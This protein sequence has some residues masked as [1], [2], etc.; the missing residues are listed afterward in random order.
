MRHSCVTY[1]HF[2]V[3]TQ[4]MY[5]NHIKILS[6]YCTYN[7]SQTSLCFYTGNL[8]LRL[9]SLHHL[10]KTIVHILWT[11]QRRR[12]T[13]KW[14]VKDVRLVICACLS[15]LPVSALFLWATPHGIRMPSKHGPT[16]RRLRMHSHLRPLSVCVIMKRWRHKML[17]SWLRLQV[18]RSRHRQVMVIHLTHLMRRLTLH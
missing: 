5:P 10:F 8:V 4:L 6:A 13:W 16:E 15:E 7:L 9:T 3:G 2:V 11:S 14:S 1:I 17:V 12:S 18:Q